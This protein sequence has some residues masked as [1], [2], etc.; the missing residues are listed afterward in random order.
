M[1]FSIEKLI[2]KVN[3]PVDFVVQLLGSLFMCSKDFGR[4]S[5][6]RYLIIFEILV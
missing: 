3:P 1:S 6:G 2:R 4:E 5:K